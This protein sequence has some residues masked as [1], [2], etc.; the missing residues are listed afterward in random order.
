MKKIIPIVSILSAGV[1]LSGCADSNAKVDN[2]DMLRTISEFETSVDA[3]TNTDSD[4]LT[5]VALNKYKLTL[6]IPKD[7]TL[8]SSENSNNGIMTLEEPPII[9]EDFSLNEKSDK[10]ATTD[11]ES[12]ISPI[13]PSD[14]DTGLDIDNTSDTDDTA[15]GSDID[16][17]TIEED[18]PDTSED[19]TSDEQGEADA[20]EDLDIEDISTLYSLTEDIDGSC[21]E[22]CELKEEI[23]EAITETENL[24]KKVQSQEIKLT[25]EQ[26]MFISEQAKQLKKLGRELTN[27]TNELVYN[28]SDISTLLRESDSSIDDLS[29]R[30]LVVLNNLMNGNNILENG[31]RSLYMI[32]HL[33]NTDPTNNPNMRGEILYGFRKNNEDPII[34]NYTI[35]NGEIT[36]NQLNNQTDENTADDDQESTEIPQTNNKTNIDTY[37]TNKKN[38]DS[39]F[40]TALLDNRFMY[41]NGNNM[42]NPYMNYNNNYANMQNNVNN[43]TNGVNNIENTQDTGMN[44]NQNTDTTKKKEKRFK[45]NI[46]TYRD[47]NTPTLSARFKNFKQSVSEFFSK[48]KKPN[49]AHYRTPIHKLNNDD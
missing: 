35:E 25:A 33:Y 4:R 44:N 13:T 21:E 24:I 41:G 12:R 32:N 22:F 9:D 7:A 11:D 49:D 37:N 3:Y 28:L 31:L 30:Y 48:F 14:T 1:L 20:D 6:S 38:I 42:Y 19:T 43:T 8:V 16:N 39:F 18:T 45:K 5:K 17:D 36:E 40:N 26:R 47:E 15:N 34:K 27:V 46:D 10:I 2:S 29:L 23:N